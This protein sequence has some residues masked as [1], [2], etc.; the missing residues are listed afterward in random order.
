VPLFA[1]MLPYDLEK[2]AIGDDFGLRLAQPILGV[3]RGWSGM[4]P[5][6]AGSGC[7]E[8]GPILIWK[9]LIDFRTK[10]DRDLSLR[11]WKFNIGGF[12]IADRF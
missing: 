2:Q 9:P 11:L 3:P 7:I 10:L 6:Q 4:W 1:E 5:G 12:L 8:R